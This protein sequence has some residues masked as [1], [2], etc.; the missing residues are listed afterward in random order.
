MSKD[1]DRLEKVIAVALNPG[2]YEE[3]AITALRRARELV[4]QDPQL[5][6]APPPPAPSPEPPPPVE[7]S[8]AFQVTK[9]PPYWINIFTNNVS[10]AAYGLGLKSKIV[11]EL[12][13]TP[14]AIQIRCDGPKQACAVFEAHLNWLLTY[15]N[16]QPPKR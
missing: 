2:A 10:E 6:H 16:T 11:V 14:R 5:A 3:E 8:L 1:R 13:E 7:H 12:E 15:I 4:R 9:I